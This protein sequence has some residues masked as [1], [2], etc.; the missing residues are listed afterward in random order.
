MFINSI[1]K[2]ITGY[3][4][5]KFV[6]TSGDISP[7]NPSM[8]PASD[9]PVKSAALPE[10]NDGL[11]LSEISIEYPKLETTLVTTDLISVKFAVE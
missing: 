7:K 11:L 1:S 5:V 6:I 4:S 8:V 10:I 9:S 3:S 2:A